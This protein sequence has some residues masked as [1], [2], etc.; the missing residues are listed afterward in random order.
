M[1]NSAPQPYSN[2]GER[3][4][5]RIGA[6]RVQEQLP[7]AISAPGRVPSGSGGPGSLPRFSQ[8]RPDAS[9][10]PRGTEEAPGGSAAAERGFVEAE[11]RGPE[12]SQG[13]PRP[14]AGL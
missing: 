2:R 10:P 8:C 14:I 11:N 9:S 12:Q 4:K 5:L 3:L 1:V 6:A 7:S 13:A